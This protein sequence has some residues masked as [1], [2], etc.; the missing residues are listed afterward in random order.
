M[1]KSDAIFYKKGEKLEGEY[2]MLSRTV[3]TFSSKLRIV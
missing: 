2:Q 1:M 3:R